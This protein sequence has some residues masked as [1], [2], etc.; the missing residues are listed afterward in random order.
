LQEFGYNPLI[1]QPK[2]SALHLFLSQFSSVIVWILIVA[3][4][5]AGVLGSG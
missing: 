2:V 3:A 4:T 1:E 5:I